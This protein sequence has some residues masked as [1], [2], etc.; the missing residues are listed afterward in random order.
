LVQGGIAKE[1]SFGLFQIRERLRHPRTAIGWNDKQIYLV[2][3]DGRQAGVSAGMTYDEMA[4]YMV[5]LGCTEALNLDGGGSSTM[6]VLGQVVN[7]PSKGF[8]RGMANA[9]VLVRKDSDTPRE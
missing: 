8:E 4:A 6:W 5:K 2:Q 1:F 9:L 7:N 3:V